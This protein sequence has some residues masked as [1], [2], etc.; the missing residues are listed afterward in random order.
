[1]FKLTINTVESG[2]GDIIVNYET[3]FTP[4]S[5]VACAHYKQINVCR[6][7]FSCADIIN[8]SNIKI[9]GCFI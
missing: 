8:Q 5:N 7:V 6:G 3:Y 9:S 2:C 4:F 1:M